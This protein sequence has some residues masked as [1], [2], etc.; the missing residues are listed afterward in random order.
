MIEGVQG[1][2]RYTGVY[3]IYSSTSLEKRMCEIDVFFPGG[4]V[5]YKDLWPSSPVSNTFSLDAN[6]LQ[7]FKGRKYRRFFLPS[8]LTPKDFI[9]SYAVRQGSAQSCPF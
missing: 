6:E 9:L 2:F 7:I 5:G 3:D 1:F 4:R 8:Q